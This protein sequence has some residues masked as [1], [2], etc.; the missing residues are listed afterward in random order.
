MTAHSLTAPE[1]WHPMND[2]KTNHR[3]RKKTVSL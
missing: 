1:T 2:A 3:Q